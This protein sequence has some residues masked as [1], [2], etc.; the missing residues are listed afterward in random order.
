MSYTFTDL[1]AWGNYFV[2]DS[3][4]NLGQISGGGQPSN[5]NFP[6]IANKQLA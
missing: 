4:D 3:I 2:P 5:I 1:S 6:T